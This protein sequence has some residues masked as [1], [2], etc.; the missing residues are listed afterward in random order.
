[1]RPA[2][3]AYVLDGHDAA[4]VSRLLS[5]EAIRLEQMATAVTELDWRI[6]QVRTLAQSF[7]VGSDPG[8]GAR[9]A[10]VRTA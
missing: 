10:L 4:L 5:E 9:F 7:F 2:T 6:R 8:A 1:M 3:E